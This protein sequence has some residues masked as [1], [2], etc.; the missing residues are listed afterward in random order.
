MAKKDHHDV[1][2]AIPAASSVIECD[3]V[4]GLF[5]E[6]PTFVNRQWGIALQ[7]AMGN[8]GIHMARNF[9]VRRFLDTDCT[10]LLFID[11]DIAWEPGALTRI[12]THPVD[13]VLGLYRLKEPREAYT[14]FA[15]GELVRDPKHGLIPIKAGPAGFM[16]I[17]RSVIEKMVDKLPPKDEGGWMAEPMRPDYGLP[18]LFSFNARR[19][20]ETGI[21]HQAGE[22]MDFCLRWGEM[23]GQVWL[24]PDLTLHHIGKAKYSSN[25]WQSYSTKRQVL[26]GPNGGTEIRDPRERAK[27]DELVAGV[28]P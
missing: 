4:L 16:R 15:T 20:P 5:H 12:I 17:R 14:Y 6:L 26:H 11:A 9:L 22:D 24:D 19:N 25:F 13:F 3:L 18:V 7:F 8:N 27:F 28:A 1:F 10:D 21:V 23:G 2:I